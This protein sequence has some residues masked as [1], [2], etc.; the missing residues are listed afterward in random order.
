M[1]TA[2]HYH[3]HMV[4]IDEKEVKLQIIH[5]SWNQLLLTTPVVHG[6]RM[7]SITICSNNVIE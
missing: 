6:H 7:L 5:S 1:L 3:S 2:F 4:L